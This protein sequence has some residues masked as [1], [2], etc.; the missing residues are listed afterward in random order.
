MDHLTAVVASS[1]RVARWNPPRHT[2]RSSCPDLG[3]SFAYRRIVSVLRSLAAARRDSCPPA[4][5]A[6]PRTRPAVSCAPCPLRPAA[7]T[8][9]R[10]RRARALSHRSCLRDE[11]VSAHS[12]PGCP[13]D[14]LRATALGAESPLHRAPCSPPCNRFPGR[15]ARLGTP[16]PQ[17]PTRPAR[18]HA[19][20]SEVTRG[21]G[22]SF[23]IPPD[24]CPPGSRL[25][26]HQQRLPAPSVPAAQ[27]STVSVPRDDDP[28]QVDSPSFGFPNP[29]SSPPELASPSYLE[30]VHP[31]DGVDP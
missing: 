9:R 16:V 5:A 7:D 23:D 26:Q 22:P 6:S 17:L 4:V 19:L 3:A 14:E 8:F 10:H 25:R 27:R 30:P 21:V 31:G 24:S 2:P 15:P 18:L 29:S 11:A 12:P 28:R 1:D 13:C 20:H